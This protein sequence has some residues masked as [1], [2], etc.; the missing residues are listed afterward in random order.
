MCL[1]LVLWV[2]ETGSQYPWQ[3]WIGTLC[4]DH[5]DLKLAVIVTSLPLPLQGW[6]HTT[7][8]PHPIPHTNFHVETNPQ[9]EMLGG[10]P[11]GGCPLLDRIGD[12]INKS[13]AVYEPGWGRGMGC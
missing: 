5:T 2:F 12:F 3:T 4:A 13:A 7:G 10:G 11:L 6:T 8:P 1:V 9:C